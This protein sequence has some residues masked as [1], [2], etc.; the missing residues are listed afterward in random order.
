MNHFL[1]RPV[2][3]ILM[4]SFVM[5]SPSSLAEEGQSGEDSIEEIVVTGTYLSQMTDDLPSP[6]SVLDQA[7]LSRLGAMDMKDVLRSLTFNSGA[8]GTS[9]TAF[10]GDDN[11]TGNAS[12]NLRNLGNSATLVLVNGKRVVASSYDNGGGGF[13][14]IQA[15]LPNISID[16]IEVVKD[17]AS[18]LYGSDAIAGVVNFITKADP[19][20]EFQVDYA[21]DDETGEQTDAL[22]ALRAAHDTGSGVISLAASYLDRG[23]L[24]IGDR[25]DT[26]GRSGLSTFGQPGRYVPLGAPNPTPSYF[27][28]NGGDPSS[29][30]GSQPDP[31]CDLVAAADGP[32]GVQGTFPGGLCLYDF[33]SFFP[34]VREATQL[35]V[36]LDGTHGVSD[37]LEL[38][39]S[40]TYAENESS[41]PNSLYPDVNF[42][43]ILPNHFGLQ[44]DAARRGMAPLPYLALQR[45]MGGTV[46]SSNEERPIGTISSVQR[47]TTRLVFGG[48]YDFE[49]AERP[50]SLDLSVTNSNFDAS[51][52][53]PSDTLTSNVNA[54]YVGLGGPS[55][56]QATGT[57]G[58]GNL[59]TG[60]CYFYNSFQ[61]SR[62][63]PV[64]GQLWNTSDNS[65]WAADASITVAEAARKYMNP[66]ELLD[67]MQ[68]LILIDA[69]V[70]QSVFN[71][72]SAG[73][74]LDMAHGPLALAIGVQ[75]R[76][77]STEVDNGD[78][79]NANNFKFVYGAADWDNTITSYA[80][81]SEVQAPLANWLNLNVSGRFE[82]FDELDAETFDPKIGLVAFPN[83]SITLRASWGTSFRVGSLQQTGGSKTTLENSTDA[84]SGTGGLA[85]RPSIS[86]GNS[87]LDP[88][89]ATVFNL[90]FVWT[91]FGALDGLRVALDYYSYEYDQLI[92]RE[93]HQFVINLDNALRCPSGPNSN[94]SVGPL[95]GTSD[96]DGDGIVEVYSIGAGLPDK[97]IRS[98]SGSLLRTETS[99]FN[100]PS[101]DTSGIDL[102]ASYDWD[103]GNFG[104]FS[105]KLG[106][107]YTLDYEMTLE[108]GSEI[109]G[110]GSRNAGNSI[111]R[112][113]PQYKANLV[114]GWLRG[115]HSAFV[116]VNH[117]DEYED[118]VPQSGLRGAFIG[119]A[120]TIESMTTVD[121]QYSLAL[122]VP[123]AESATSALTLGL[124]NAFNEEPPLVN[125]D[126]AYDY[127]THDP[128]GRILYARYKVEL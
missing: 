67:W 102:E 83:D 105:A 56:D 118:D 84:F 92:A 24:T 28:P 2:W 31:D 59:G 128:R 54:A 53:N 79:L 64:T 90:G 19:G 23:Q 3:A 62:Y 122:P 127:Y 112:S 121:V 57:P 45:M 48:T 115:G 124:K 1:T 78:E 95:C 51:T 99:Y 20:Y 39:G 38:Y 42:A 49:L 47:E 116:T 123:G 32:M 86:T 55:C 70:E 101:L 50:W 58:S 17:G 27:H 26:Y 7:D 16:R 66:V 75:Y 8:L 103:L 18:S 69:E 94:P 98:G 34:L 113:L 109:D 80:V 44:L 6:V 30:V 100:A 46:E 107:S 77:D 114:L 41:R 88:E 117:I 119:F 73:E 11:S 65:P 21:S 106:L 35:K 40:V 61:T 97:V 15:L 29:F 82:S 125:V 13:V 4:C 22:F 120:E 87:E 12:V 14:D 76:K 93:G 60:N 33:S 37:Q 63:D 43:I 25:Y 5:C 104:Y 74:L 10:Y 9:S 36:H 108:D 110:V 96:Q 71:M 81:F 85:F 72:V 126:G 91:P 52:Y 89:E 111:G 68:G